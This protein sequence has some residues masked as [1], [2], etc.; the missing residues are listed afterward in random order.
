MR[1]RKLGSD[2]SVLFYASRE[3]SIKIRAC[4][5]ANER[6]LDSSDVLIW[7]LRETCTQTISNGALWASQGENFDRRRTAWEKY[8]ERK[9]T[10]SE[11]ADILL[12]PESRTLEELYGVRDEEDLNGVVPRSARQEEI[13]A[14]CR[15]FGIQPGRSSALLEE[16]ERELAHEKE[17]ER[18]VQRAVGATPLS[19]SLDPALIALVETGLYPHSLKHSSLLECLRNTTQHSTLSELSD[20]FFQSKQLLATQDF[21]CTIALSSGDS[22]DDFLRAVQWILTAT[23]SPHKLLLLSPFEANELLPRVRMSENASLHMYSPR[24]SRNVRSIE[25]LNFFTV[26]RRDF[27]RPDSRIMHELNLFSGQ[28]FFSD[29]KSL[30]EVCHM[31]GLCLGEIP[32]ALQGKID[33]GG[34]AQDEGVRRIL[35][36]R[37]CL[38]RANPLAALRE[39]VGWRRKG[40]GYNLTHVGLMLHGNNLGDNEFTA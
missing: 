39:L 29:R 31:L 5:D 20:R 32:D 38:F 28:L 15:E 22:L 6:A 14:R 17:E 30:E 18:Q 27:S 24:T 10:H 37:N 23:N 26:S 1:M 19:H 11:V 25:D 16:Q 35:D 34:F 21:A 4:V 9:L 12:E 3:I 40:Q 7:A 13:R 36:I 33:V 8:K 2:H